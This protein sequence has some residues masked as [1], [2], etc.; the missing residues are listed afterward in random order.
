MNEFANSRYVMCFLRFIHL[1]PPSSNT[2]QIVNFLIGFFSILG[3]S[4]AVRVWSSPKVLSQQIRDI[5]HQLLSEHRATWGGDPLATMPGEATTT[6]SPSKVATAN[7]TAA[8]ERSDEIAWQWG[9]WPFTT[10]T[11]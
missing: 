1:S 3:T 4:T 10:I 7:I 5:Q 11:D 6:I 8:I 9:F 2:Q